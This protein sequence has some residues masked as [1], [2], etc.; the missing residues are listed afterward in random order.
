MHGGHSANPIDTKNSSVH[1]EDASVASSSARCRRR[2]RR[3]VAGQGEVLRNHEEQHDCVHHVC[4]SGRT[5][6]AEQIVSVQIR[7]VCFYER[8][9]VLLARQNAHMPPERANLYL[10]D[11]GAPSGCSSTKKKKLNMT[12]KAF[13]RLG[14]TPSTTPAYS[15]R[16]SEEV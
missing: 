10:H 3:C 15:P 7:S 5:Q 8:F 4:K 13:C 1:A 11:G 9:W 2:Q 14:R 16:D 12:Q 6:D